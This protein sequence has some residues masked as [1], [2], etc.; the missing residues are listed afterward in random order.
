M[1]RM[2]LTGNKTAAYAARV[3]EA[4]Y[5]AAYPITPQSEIVETLAQWIEA[6]LM[7]ARFVNFE[8]E[9]SMVTAAGAAS[10]AGV[11]AFTATSSQGLFYAFEAL[12]TVSGWR[13]P[14]VLV[15]VSRGVGMPMI[16]QVEHGD[17]LAARDSGFIQLHAE[18]CQEVLDLILLGYRVGEDSKILLPVLVNMDGFVLSFAREPVE[19][20]EVDEVRAFLPKY[21]RPRPL[22]GSEPVVYGPTLTDGLAY[23]FFKYGMHRAMQEAEKV[24]EEAAKEFGDRFGRTHEPVEGNWL[25]D[26]EIA[27]ISSNSF[28]TSIRSAVKT[29]RER[30]VP[31]GLLKLKMIRPFPRERLAEALKGVKA[32]AVFE[33][34]LAPGRGG[35]LYPEIVEAL[36][37]MGKRPAVLSFI[38]GIGGM[39]VGLP[40]VETMVRRCREALETGAVSKHPILLV[41]REDAERLRTLLETATAGP[42]EVEQVSKA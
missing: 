24:F 17:V 19:V 31:V 2:L 5:V 32:V 9:H 14:I 4:G 28:T 18:T 12:Y 29:L 11:R 8:S 27:I 7:K 16:L 42:L 6:G 34:N 30:G 35:A 10:L 22:D 23:L 1:A 40:E 36:Y 39:Q 26:A 20:P 21:N 3:A 15:N 25:D 38:G 37:H 13:A 33:Q 41:R